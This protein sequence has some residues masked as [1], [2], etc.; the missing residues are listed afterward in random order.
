MFITMSSPTKFMVVATLR[1]RQNFGE[2]FGI[3]KHSSFYCFFRT[4]F[5]NANLLI[6]NQMPFILVL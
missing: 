5:N 2:L 3:K 1:Y 6:L 4:N